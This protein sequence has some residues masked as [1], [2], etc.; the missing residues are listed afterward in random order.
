MTQR[1]LL[2]FE[3]R[4][5]FAPLLQRL[6]QG[7]EFA[8]RAWTA[9]EDLQQAVQTGSGVVM[10]VT[11]AA[12]EPCLNLLGRFATMATPPRTIVVASAHAATLEWPAR[13]LGATAFVSNRIPTGELVDLCKRLM[14]D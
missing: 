9:A 14:T 4:P 8:V 2:V 3:R 5:R 6:F 10:L 12:E 7:T 13:E 1:S 11:E